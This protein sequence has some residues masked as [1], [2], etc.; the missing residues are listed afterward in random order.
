[1]I[2]EK[3]TP[4]RLTSWSEENGRRAQEILPELVA[5]LI[6]SSCSQINN[7]H[8]PYGSGIQYPGYDGYIESGPGNNYISKGTSVFEFGTNGNI[9]EKFNSDIK[10]RSKNPKNIIMEETDFI[11][12]S[13]KIWNHKISIPEKVVNAKNEYG[14]RSVKIVD[15]QS[16]CL[17]LDENFAVST[18]LS[19]IIN[20]SVKGISSIEKFWDE[21]IGITEPKLTSEFFIYERKKKVEELEKFILEGTGYFFIKAESVDEALFFLIST[22]KSMEEEV[23]HKMIII[24]EKETWDAIT[25]L[26]N[27]KDVIFV[28]IFPI[29]D[30]ISCPS[31][32]NAIFPI[33]KFIPL[34]KVSDNFDGIEIFKFKHDQFQNA[35]LNLGFSYNEITK[36]EKETKRCFLPL[37]RKLST[38][39][40]IKQPRW[41]S[42]LKDDIGNLIPIML[43]NYLDIESEGDLAILK[44][45]TNDSNDMFLSK[46]DEWTKMEDFPI[47][48]T[49]DI[50]RVV[51]TQDMWTFLGE[52][53]KK[54]DIKNLEKAI[55]LIFSET[56]PKYDLS[57]DQRCMANI[58]GKKDRYSRQLVEGLLVSLIF[59]KEK[60]SIFVKTIV[61]STESFVH[62]LIRDVMDNIIIE[63]QWLSI[64]EFFPLLTET[65]PEAIVSKL[66][67]EINN[68]KSEFI[69]IFNAESG[70]SIFSGEVYHYFLWAIERLAWVKEH[71]VDAIL[72]LTKLADKKFV[73]SNGNSPESSLLQV[74]NNI[75]PQTVLSREEIA[76]L[77]GKI[78]RDYPTVGLNIVMELSGFNNHLYKTMSRPE[79]IEYIDPYN[80][81]YLSA[82]EQSN[83]RTN[84]IDVFFDNIMDEANSDV[85]E[86]IFSNIRYFYLNYDVKIKELVENNVDKFSDEERLSILFIIRRTISDDKKYSSSVEKLQPKM[87][88]FLEEIFSILEPKSSLKYR[89]LCMYSPP[90]MNPVPYTNSIEDIEKEDEEIYFERSSA[91]KDILESYGLDEFFSYCEHIEDTGAFAYIIVNDVLFGAFKIE[92]LLKVMDANKDLF[93]SMIQYLTKNDITPMLTALKKNVDM[94]WEIEAKILCQATQGLALW[95][96]VEKKDEKIVSY[97]WKHVERFSLFFLE[98][99]ESDFYLS[100]LVEHGRVIDAIN[101]S[102]FS[103]Y[104]NYSMNLHLLISLKTFLDDPSNHDSIYLRSV[105]PRNIQEILKKINEEKNKDIEVIALLELY[106][107][108]ILPFDF[109]PKSMNEWVKNQPEI[110]VQLIQRLYLNDD[111]VGTDQPSS[112]SGYY[113]LLDSLTI[114]PGCSDNNLD[115]ERFD[116]WVSRV[117]DI[118]KK[119]NFLRGTCRALGTLLSHSPNGYDGI[120]PHEFIREF[121]EKNMY[122]K[123]ILEDLVPNFITGRINT[124]GRRGISGDAEKNEKRRGDQYEIDANMIQIDYPET[125]SILKQLKENYHWSSKQFSNLED[126]Y[127]D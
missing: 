122:K 59:L 56:V 9:Q 85:Y 33:S 11:F 66:K 65:C 35:L 92:F 107:I 121:F 13:S 123:E 18:W 21:T 94:D 110:Y 29:E 100:K 17:W 60:D 88:A 120:F 72:L 80:N 4:E 58:L 67:K 15:A 104:N 127:F 40:F 87:I 34:S 39:P 31:N 73:L 86:I 3:I 98:D 50:Y 30:N 95:E 126:R 117:L 101:S 49:R 97:F 105:D 77:L 114:I 2:F 68:P 74:F 27:I 10:K 20:G 36:V 70:N 6:F 119:S 83:F 57:T 99:R 63:K 8:I 52:K 41:L 43:L 47:V 75:S 71:A 14:W 46:L 84:I 55:T 118:A 116:T 5:R 82:E 62:V 106:Y 26:T 96:E 38:N 113:R 64:A 125:A 69:K 61:G 111:G 89:Y 91:I 25:Q 7:F 12:V 22:I 78:L 1:M 24:K 37:Y 44:I 54:R 42:S 108:E 53:L 109:C 48:N 112:V 93:K 16:L 81:R 102:A 51:S 103:K 90:R 23:S 79:W 115:K 76:K 45:L 19:E 28:P 32:M 124:L